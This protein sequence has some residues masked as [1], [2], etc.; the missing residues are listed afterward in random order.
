M[1][2]YLLPLAIFVVLAVVLAVALQFNNRDIVPSPLVGEAAPALDGPRLFAPDRRLT[3]ADI[4]GQVAL[5][6]VWASWCVACRQEHAYVSALAERGVPIYGLNYKDTRAEAKAWLSEFGDPYVA[7]VFDKRG[8][9]GMDWG[10]YGVPET[11]ILD[12]GGRIR[13]KHIGAITRESMKEEILPRV[14]RLRE[15]AGS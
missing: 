9:I 2:R 13:Y 15:E 10:V 7:H 6:N 4:R 1:K 5:V 11:F 3:L 8:S 12:A 14:R